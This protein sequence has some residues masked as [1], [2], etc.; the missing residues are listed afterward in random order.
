VA[1][2]KH[3]DRQEDKHIAYMGKPKKLQR[4]ACFFLQVRKLS[5]GLA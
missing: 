2:A 5:L 3:A 4:Q 1:L